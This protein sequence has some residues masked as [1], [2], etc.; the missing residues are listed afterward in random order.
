[1]EQGS[2]T[3]PVRVGLVIGQLTTGGAEGQ[4]WLLCRDLDRRRFTPIVYCLSDDTA[5]YAESIA[6]S[7]VRVRVV[8]GGRLT[9]VRTLQRWLAADRI[10]VVHA[11][12]FVA[13]GFAWVANRHARRPLVTSARNCKR[14]GRLLD[15]LNR[16]AF[17]ASAAIVVN[18]QDVGTYVA[19][20][21][22]A[23]RERIRLIYNGIDTRRFHPAGEGSAMAATG[24]IV[25]VG[26][27]VAQKNHDLFLR[28]AQQLVR[29]RPGARF[30]IV[31][32][33]PLRLTLTARAS[34][35]GIADQVTFA[36]ECKDV[37]Q[38]LRGA[39]LFWLTSRWE[40]LPNVVLE[41][42]AS[43]VPVV[44]TDV[45]GTRELIRSGIDGFIV[46]DDDQDGFVRHSRELLDNPALRRQVGV[47]ARVRAEEFSAHQMVDRFAR[48]YEDVA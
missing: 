21:Y 13:N 47:A 33:G 34:Q 48:L 30:V 19:R 35:L 9:R 27:L 4:L 42:L 7:G 18:S 43:G 1:V 45:G 12:L 44:A 38:V 11:W 10:G 40:G 41:A 39:S 31:G 29:E 24:P 23:P 20:H 46:P 17:R 22:A 14:Q 25:T 16:W 37:E 6:A 28:A 3:G 32:E 5:P 36:G 26:R 2:V 15:L 8:S